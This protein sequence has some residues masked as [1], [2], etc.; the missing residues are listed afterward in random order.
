MFPYPKARDNKHDGL[1][2]K[3]IKNISESNNA[4]KMNWIW[5]IEC[6]FVK[7]CAYEYWQLIIEDFDPFGS[8][9]VNKYSL[10]SQGRL[11]MVKYFHSIP[12]MCLD[13]FHAFTQIKIIIR[14]NIKRLS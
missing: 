6:K 2:F 3:M 7:R 12:K 5:K 10:F 13:P 14:F 1:R 11:Y 8:D 4:S 9:G